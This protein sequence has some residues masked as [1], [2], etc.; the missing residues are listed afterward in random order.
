MPFRLDKLRSYLISVGVASPSV[1][2][3]EASQQTDSF[4]LP[5]QCISASGAQI[6][7]YVLWGSRSVSKPDGVHGYFVAFD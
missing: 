6:Q 3:V 1:N 2:C 7:G 4:R 5:V